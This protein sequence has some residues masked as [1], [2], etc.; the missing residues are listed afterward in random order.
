MGHESS[1]QDYVPGIVIAGNDRLWFDKEI[2]TVLTRKR[3]ATYL[4]QL[5]R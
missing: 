1:E 4:T 3:L 5:G 2:E